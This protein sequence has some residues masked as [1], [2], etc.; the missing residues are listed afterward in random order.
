MSR[1]TTGISTKVLE[2]NSQW[3]EVLIQSRVEVSY[4]EFW[5]RPDWSG[6]STVKRT[7]SRF[8]RTCLTVRLEERENLTSKSQNYRTHWKKWVPWFV[9]RLRRDE[10]YRAPF[11]KRSEGAWPTRAS[12]YPSSPTT[13]SLP[14]PRSLGTWDR[15]D[16]LNTHCKT[17][18]I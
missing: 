2:W 8:D 17:W 12:H 14:F 7:W 1:S 15:S 3:P 5:K 10:E 11:S 16:D 6:Y 18:C 4:H 13:L 9:H